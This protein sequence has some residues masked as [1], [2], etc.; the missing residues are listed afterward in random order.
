VDPAVKP[1]DDVFGNYEDCVTGWIEGR[2]F[3]KISARL[4]LALYF[5]IKKNH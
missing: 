1:Q 5:F 2:G 4:S 3:A